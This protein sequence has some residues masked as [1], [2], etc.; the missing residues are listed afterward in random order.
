MFSKPS[1]STNLAL[2]KGHILRSIHREQLLYPIISINQSMVLRDALENLKEKFQS[3]C[4]R[5][6]R[7]EDSSFIFSLGFNF[8]FLMI[9]LVCVEII[10]LYLFNRSK[11]SLEPIQVFE[12]WLVYQI[13]VGFGIPVSIRNDAESGIPKILS[14]EGVDMPDLSIDT[15]CV[16]MHEIVFLSVLILAF[17]G[18]RLKTKMKWLSI[19]GVFIFFENIARIAVAYPMV[20]TFGWD[21]WNRFH[22]YFWQ[23]GQLIIVMLLFL[24]WFIF[25]AQKEV[26]ENFKAKESKKENEI[27]KQ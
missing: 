11:D 23:Y 1:R 22:F 6:E 7:A 21:N 10:Y 3:L 18:V 26:A 17:R 27:H 5:L 12:T 15:A 16:G 4:K 24:L 8:I 19:F 14:Y 13:Q 9:V 2:Q 25:V 20:A